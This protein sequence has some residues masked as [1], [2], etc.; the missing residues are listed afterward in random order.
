MATRSLPA[1][2]D[3]RGLKQAAKSLLPPTSLSLRMIE[4]QDDFLPDTKAR[5]V[6]AILAR[7]LWE[8]IRQQPISS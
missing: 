6:V 8:E 7:I 2:R 4:S 3:L 1:T 5:V